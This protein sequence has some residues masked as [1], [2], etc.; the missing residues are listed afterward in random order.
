MGLRENDLAKLQTAHDYYLAGEGS[1][2]QHGN[3]LRARRLA[4]LLKD[5]P[6]AVPAQPNP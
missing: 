2:Q 5:R 3:Q 4:P 1:P 6:A